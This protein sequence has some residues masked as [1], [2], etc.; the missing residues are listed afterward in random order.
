MIYIHKK[1]KLGSGSDTSKL[2]ETLKI[3]ATGDE[4]KIPEF[5]KE[6]GLSYY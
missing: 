1:L 3:W 2:I 5:F 4:A 6:V